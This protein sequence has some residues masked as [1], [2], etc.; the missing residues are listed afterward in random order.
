MEW[1][2]S[3]EWVVL[4]CVPLFIILKYP[5]QVTPGLLKLGG[6]YVVSHE[7]WGGGNPLTEGASTLE[8]AWS[9]HVL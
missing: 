1:G 8:K 2:R 9:V 7:R 3:G 6:G 4:T 5:R